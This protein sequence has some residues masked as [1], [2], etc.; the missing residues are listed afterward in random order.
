MRDPENVRIRTL[1]AAATVALLLTATS[2]AENEP[3]TAVT[4]APLAVEPVAAPTTIPPGPGPPDGPTTTTT[5][6]GVVEGLDELDDLDGFDG[7]EAGSEVVIGRSVEDRPI[8]VVRRGDEGG[9]RVLVVGV[10]HGDEDAG[11][12]IVDVLRLADV[13]DGVELWLVRSMNPDGQAAQERHNAHGVDLNRNFSHNWGPVAEP[14]NWEYAGEG[15]A[16]EPETQAMTALGEGVHP[17]LVLWYHQD[18]FRIS[19]GS[20]RDGEIRARYAGLTGLPLVEVTGGT[21]T[22]TASQWSRTVV[23]SG[24]VGFTIELGPSLTP[25]EVTTHAEAV[26]TIAS[27]M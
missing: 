15:P 9:T 22:G 7:I 25:D 14:G 18:L 8:T 10:I 19:P 23:D 13:P 17:D 4:L 26:L 12:D 3:E 6:P 2:C 5:D 24:G 1:V 16:S 20:G 11:A 27:E 21:Y